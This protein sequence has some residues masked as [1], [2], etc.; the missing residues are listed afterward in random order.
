MAK[1]QKCW[2]RDLQIILSSTLVKQ[3][4]VFGNQWTKGKTDLDITVSGTKYLSP[5]KDNFVIT[6]ANLTYSEVLK[7]IKSKYYQVEIKAGY[8]NNNVSNAKTIFKGEVIYVS[9]EK[10]DNETN[11]IIL[12]VGSKLVAKY[13]QSRLNLSLNSGINMYSAISFLCRRAGIVGANISSDFKNQIIKDGISCDSTVGNWL[14][15]FS[16]INNLIVNSD[17]SDNELFSIINPRKTNNRVITLTNESITLISGYPKLNSD[18][19]SLTILPT[20]NFKPMDVIV[21]DNSIIDVSVS[22]NNPSEFNNPNFLDNDGKYL[23]TE[24]S[25]DLTNRSS[26]FNIT[27]TAKAR[28][29]FS[30]LKGVTSYGK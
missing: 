4:L 15:Q 21:I 9:N 14:E 30:E 16:N 25:Y 2:M 18:G 7:I 19:L 11:T 20:F 24:I 1:I 29:L 12:I 8:R 27:I 17:S 5:V 10:Q 23:I 28:K 26:N 3:S 22:S 6:I 13:G